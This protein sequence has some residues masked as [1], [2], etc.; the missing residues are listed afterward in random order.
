MAVKIRMKR[1]GRLH[2]SFYRIAAVDSRAPRDGRVIEELGV[3]DPQHKSTDMQFRL[4]MDRV[5]YWLSVGAV[6][7]ETVSQLLAKSGVQ[8]R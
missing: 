3:Y 2:R 5:K 6:P 7:S 8:A 1:M 4:N